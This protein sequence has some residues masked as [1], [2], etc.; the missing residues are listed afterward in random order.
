MWIIVNN[1][2]NAIMYRESRGGLMLKNI[3]YDKIID[4]ICYVK[5]ITRETSFKILKDR[6]CK[7]ILFLLLRKYKCRDIQS[8]YTDYICSTKRATNYCLKKAEER[9]FINKEFR[10][11]YFEIE[12]ILDKVE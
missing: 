11:M 9:F 7:Y 12:S 8:A 3:D 4:A 10:E 5:G 2:I 1:L 6:E